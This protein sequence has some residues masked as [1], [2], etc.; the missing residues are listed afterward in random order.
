VWKSSA[1]VAEV[2]VGGLQ[3]GRHRE[4]DRGSHSSFLKGGAD[5][6]AAVRVDGEQVVDAFR[7][8]NVLGQFE[9]CPGP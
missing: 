5:P 9:V 3:V 2:R 1:F 8:R 4:V 6:I 7:V